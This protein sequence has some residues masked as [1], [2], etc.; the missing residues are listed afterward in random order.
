[1][2]GACAWRLVVD[3]RFDGPELDQHLWLPFYLPHWNSRERSAARFTLG[4]GG[5][6]LRV[7]PDQEPWHPEMDPGVRVSSLQTGAFAGPLGSSI[8]QH[9]FRSGLAV[10]E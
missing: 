10:R 7:D 9:R 6:T 1:M 8:G 2:D 4:N 3:E 5:L